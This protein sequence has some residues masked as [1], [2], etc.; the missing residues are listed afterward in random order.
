MTDATSPHYCISLMVLG[1]KPGHTEVLIYG[2]NNNN[3]NYVHLASTVYH[4]PRVKN[5][6]SQLGLGLKI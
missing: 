1:I 5:I 6:R 4:L 2:T 3:N